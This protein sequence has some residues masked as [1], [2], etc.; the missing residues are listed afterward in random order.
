MPHK[1]VVSKKSKRPTPWFSDVI[2]DK[3]KH[4]N[5][6]KRK[7]EKSC[8]P[9][10]KEQFRREKNELKVM[11]RQAKIDYLQSSVLQSKNCPQKA[12]YG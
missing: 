2:A 10:D 8:D 11:V 9:A 5:I 12:S 4:K 6:A 3:I 1:K 7:A